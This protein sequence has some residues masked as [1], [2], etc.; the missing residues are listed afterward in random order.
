MKNLSDIEL[1]KLAEKISITIQCSHVKYKKEEI[2]LTASIGI[3]NYVKTQKS[4]ITL[5]ELLDEADKAMYLSK[6]NGRNQVILKHIE[7]PP[8]DRLKME[9]ITV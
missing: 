5:D 8:T 2:L 4:H 7:E 9:I 3:I 1:K 6:Q